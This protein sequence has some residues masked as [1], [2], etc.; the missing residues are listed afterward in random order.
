MGEYVSGYKV[1]TC[2]DLYYVRLT[3]LVAMRASG[4]D[5]AAPYLNP[6]NGF[7]YRFPFPDEDVLV[8]KSGR[9]D[10]GDAFDFNRGLTVPAPA[11]WTAE[12]EGPETYGDHRHGCTWRDREDDSLEIVQQKIVASEQPGPEQ[13]WTVVRCPHCSA[14]WRLDQKTGLALADGLQDEDPELAWRIRIGY[15]NGILSPI[16][17]G[18]D[19]FVTPPTWEDMA[20]IPNLPSPPSNIGPGFYSKLLVGEAGLHLLI[21]SMMQEVAFKLAHDEMGYPWFTYANLATFNHMNVIQLSPPH[22]RLLGHILSYYPVEALD[23]LVEAAWLRL[24]TGA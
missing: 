18:H 9:F 20:A 23:G 15:E 12:D 13:V 11:F 8:R 21:T 10:M 22:L 17:A 7:R 2:E 16:L 5:Q 3:G 24:K 6:R 4:K 19:P 14:M 1:G